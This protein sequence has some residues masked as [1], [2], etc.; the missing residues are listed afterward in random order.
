MKRGLIDTRIVE[1]FFDKKWIRENKLKVEKL[2]FKKSKL[3]NENIK[4]LKYIIQREF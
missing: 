4:I 2:N 3:G 1:T